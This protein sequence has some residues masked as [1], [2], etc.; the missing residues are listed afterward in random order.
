MLGSYNIR[1]TPSHSFVH[2]CA[3]GR[4]SFCIKFDA[5]VDY[6]N[7]IVKMRISYGHGFK[8]FKHHARGC[9]RRILELT[10]EAARQRCWAHRSLIDSPHNI[11][12]WGCSRE[13]VHDMMTTYKLIDEIYLPDLSD[14]RIDD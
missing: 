5:T 7:F 6:C 14:F 3:G 10:W 1:K 13:A 12:I 9:S 2:T 11:T 8:Y 4:E